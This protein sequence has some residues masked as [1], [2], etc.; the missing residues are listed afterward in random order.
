MFKMHNNR[1]RVTLKFVPGLAAPVGVVGG[2]AVRVEVVGGVA[3]PVEVVGGVV[4]TK[5]KVPKL[6]MGLSPLSEPS[7]SFVIR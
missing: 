5:V 7:V 1:R 4:F 2:V 6:L 3:V